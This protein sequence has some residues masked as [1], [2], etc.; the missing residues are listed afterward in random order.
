[1]RAMR[2]FRRVVCSGRVRSAN[3]TGAPTPCPWCPMACALHHRGARTGPRP[4]PSWLWNSRLDEDLEAVAIGHVLV[5]A[6]DTVEVGRHV[7]DLPR[8]DRALEDVGHQ[9]LDV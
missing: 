9:F 5:A 6:R 2:S 7:E 3:S 1:M 8:L 4:S